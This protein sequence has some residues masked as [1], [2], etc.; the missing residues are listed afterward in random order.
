MAVL[1]CGDNLLLAG[2]AGPGNDAPTLADASGAGDGGSALGWVE[3]AISGCEAGTVEEPAGARL[4]GGDAGPGDAGAP[5][6]EC[7]GRAPLEL[8]FTALTEARVDE[9]DW[10]LDEDVRSQAPSP[11]H[12]YELPGLYSVSLTVGGPGGTADVAKA[13]I[14]RVIPAEL[15]DRCTMSAQ[16]ASA[17]CVCGDGAVCP[18]GLETGLCSTGCSAAS[19]CAE[20]ACGDLAAAGPASPESWQRAMCLPACAGDGECPAGLTCQEL[21]DGSGAG[22]VT[23]CFAPALV[24][25]VGASC[26]DAAGDPDHEACASGFCAE[27]GAR[28]ACSALCSPGGCPPSSACGDFADP[29]A[30]L[31]VARCEADGACSA[32]PWLACEMPGPTAA[33][34][35]DEPAAQGGYCAP[36]SCAGPTECGPDG[37]CV[38]GMCQ[39]R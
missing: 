33:F 29:A 4:G 23:G 10:Q 25:P 6:Q 21:P 2:D 7:V 15:G 3:M 8:R 36:R 16:C 34:T 1:G 30:D 39:A 18:P 37:Q 5:A 22:W 32:D 12:I 26:F 13:G 9:Y 27:V 28:G 19:P 11:T 17:E 31:C 35:V 24:A 14:V 20:G 38:G